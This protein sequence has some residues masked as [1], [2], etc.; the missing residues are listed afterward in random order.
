MS[1]GPATD[2]REVHGVDQTDVMLQLD[3]EG[4]VLMLVFRKGRI[5]S[6]LC[7]DVFPGH[8]YD[9]VSVF[10]PAGVEYTVHIIVCI[11]R[12]EDDVSLLHSIVKNI[13]P[14]FKEFGNATLR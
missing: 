7:L 4:F 13:F 11:V 5:G 2:R 14:E 10:R 6:F 8:V 1:Q 9:P 12:Q 3:V